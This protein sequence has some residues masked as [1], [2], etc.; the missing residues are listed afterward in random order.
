MTVVSDEDGTRSNTWIHDERGR[1]VGVVDA[2]EQRQSTSY[3]RW[4]NPVLRHR[5]RRRDDGPRVRRPRPSR[6]ARSRPPAPTSPTATTSS[7][8]SPR[9]SPRTGAVTEY[10]YEGAL[11]EPRRRSVDPEGGLTRL[12]W[13]DGLLTRGRRPDRRR[14]ALLPTTSAATWSATTDA[15]GATARL[16]R[17]DAG[18]RHRGRHA[19]GHRTTLRLRPGLRPARRARRPGRRDL[20]L[21]AQR[22]PAGSRAVDPLGAP[23]QRRARR[24]T[25]RRPHGRPAR[26][27]GDPRSSTTSATSPRV[28]LP[29]GS[30]LGASPTT[31]CP[32]S[33]RRP[34][35]PAAA[36]AQELRRRR[37]GS[38]P[39]VDPTGVRVGVETSTRR[40]ARVEVGDGDGSSATVLRRPLGPARRRIGLPDGSTAVYTLRPLRPSRRAP[41]RRRRADRR[42]TATAAGRAVD[43]DAAR[44]AR[45]HPLRLRRAAVASRPSTDPTGA[46]HDDR[47]RRRRPAGARR[48]CRPARRRW[49]TLRRLRPGGRARRSPGAGTPQLRLRR[50][51]A[52]SSRRDDPGRPAPVPLRRRRP[53]RRGGRRQ[54]RRDHATAT[55]PTAARVDDHDPLGRA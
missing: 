9:S 54:R 13:T 52:G 24:R 7:T 8:A 55:T 21:R 45:R 5:A 46:R 36:G 10:T 39:R 26:S 47:L 22:R 20:A 27:R 32:G 49:T 1:L 34:T 33:S 29:D 4:G 23:H 43:G 37:A 11:R 28:E 41:R 30:A 48:R 16:E 3:D 50:S 44:R 6:P 53:A 14:R 18:P 31:P 35:R 2:D 40:P 15:D 19:V 12:T 51:P 17:D 42:S 25:A 38:P